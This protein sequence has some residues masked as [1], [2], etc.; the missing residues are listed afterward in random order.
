MAKPLYRGVTHPYPNLPERTLEMALSDVPPPRTATHLDASGD[1]PAHWPRRERLLISPACAAI[2]LAV[3]AHQGLDLRPLVNHEVAGALRDDPLDLRVFVAGQDGK[4]V[5]AG[6]NA[7]IVGG[8][9]V[10]ELV[11][12][13]PPALAAEVEFLVVRQ[14]L[15][16]FTHVADPLVHLAQKSLIHGDPLIM[17]VHGSRLLF[18]DRV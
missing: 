12:L 17:L 7:L 3:G 16:P 8:L 9:H 14:N 2:R 13:R 4:S 18:G 15:E 11:A 5:V 6:P 10:Q 1:I